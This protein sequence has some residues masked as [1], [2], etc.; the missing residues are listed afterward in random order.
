[1]ETL[2]WNFVTNG[3]GEEAACEFVG[4]A[5]CVGLSENWTSLLAASNMWVE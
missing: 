2:W 4:R 1:M 3:G 5:R